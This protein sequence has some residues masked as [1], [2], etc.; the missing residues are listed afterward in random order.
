MASA[1]TYSCWS[2][3]AGILAVT[4]PETLLGTQSDLDVRLR[5]QEEAHYALPE[6]FRPT[7][8]AAASDASLLAWSGSDSTVFL[9]TAGN[10]VPLDI[11]R[12]VVGGTFLDQQQIAI[13]DAVGRL[14][15][16]D[17]QGN[18]NAHSFLISTDSLVSAT[19]LGGRWYL[20]DALGTLYESPPRRRDGF[21]PF[22]RTWPELPGARPSDIRISAAPSGHLLVTSSV[23][24]F[25]VV[26]LDVTTG[27]LL[28][29]APLRRDDI[30]VALQTGEGVWRSLV[31]VALGGKYLRTLFDA[32]TDRRLL[33]LHDE[34]GRLLR[35]ATVQA[36]IG[37]AA[38]TPTHVYAVRHAGINEVVQYKWEIPDAENTCAST[39]TGRKKE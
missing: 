20:L 18:L 37:F 30:P 21:S 5:L 29:L 7:G 16:L 19:H 35:T 10:W 1:T 6:G 39:T 25:S 11:P 32:Q 13:V 22:P 28:N 8:L 9:R 23:Y 31:T 14:S 36:P 34:C 3:C 33:T 4:S 26:S 17:A 12:A 38:A 15:I 24:P 2:A 27:E